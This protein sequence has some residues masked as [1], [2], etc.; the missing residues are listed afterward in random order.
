VSGVVT[1]FASVPSAVANILDTAWRAVTFGS[2]AV[3][4]SYVAVLGAVSVVAFLKG[5]SR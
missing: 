5:R 1:F 2:P 4:W 3:G